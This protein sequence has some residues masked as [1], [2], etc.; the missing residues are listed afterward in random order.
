M[1]RF[2]SSARQALNLHANLPEAAF[3]SAFILLRL[4]TVHTHPIKALAYRSQFIRPTPATQAIFDGVRASALFAFGRL[5]PRRFCPRLPVPYHCRLPLAPFRGPSVCHAVPPKVRLIKSI[6]FA[7]ERCVIGLNGAVIDLLLTGDVG[8]P[9][10]G[11]L[12]RVFDVNE[13]LPRRS[14]LALRF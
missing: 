8:L 13:R 12:P 10:K 11:G 6:S 3:S 2:E 7:R 1:W 4:A 14:A 9:N 5:W